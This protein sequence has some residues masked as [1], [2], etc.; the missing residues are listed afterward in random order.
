M[1]HDTATQTQEQS[2]FLPKLEVIQQALSEAESVDDFFGKE[3][4]FAKLFAKT[5]EAMLEA[6]LTEHLGYGHYEAKG[7]NSGNSRNGKRPKTVRTSGGALGGNG[8]AANSASA[9]TVGGAGGDAVSQSTGTAAG[10]SATDIRD[11]AQGGAGG[12]I[13]GQA[14]STG[15][16]GAGGS[17]NSTAIASNAGT[18]NVSVQADAD[19]GSG[20]TGR[21]AGESGGTGGGGGGGAGKKVIVLGFDGMDYSITRELMASGVMPNFSRL[22]AEG[23]FCFVQDRDEVFVFH[24]ERWQAMSAVR[25][26]AALRVVAVEP[27]LE[28]AAPDAARAIRVDGRHRIADQPPGTASTVLPVDPEGV[29][30]ARLRVLLYCRLVRLG[31]NRVFGEGRGRQPGR[32]NVGV[33]SP[34]LVRAGES[35]GG[36]A[37]APPRD[38]A[39]HDA[40]ARRRYVD[41]GQRGVPRRSADRI[42]RSDRSCRFRWLWPGR[43]AGAGEWPHRAVKRPA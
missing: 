42:H 14:G 29:G 17:G 25:G 27:P 7:R 5:V 19:G 38:A 40:S 13:G 41:R 2:P 21:G 37:R 15:T 9:G 28:V 34:Q 22:A 26:K 10:N 35:A 6:E 18:S 31:G 23:Q 4:I 11:R 12:S 20:G 36:L 43:P 8:G 39:S 1:N 30:I 16:G 33:R 32:W 24:E 3:G